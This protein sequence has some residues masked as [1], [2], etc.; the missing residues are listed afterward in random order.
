[1]E[2]ITGYICNSAK[3][4]LIGVGLA[5]YLMFGVFIVVGPMFGIAAL[6]DAYSD[7]MLLLY[8]PWILTL[9]ITSKPLALLLGDS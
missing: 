5:L 7:W 3:Q 8:I 6:V 4:A 9:P 1:M 2:T